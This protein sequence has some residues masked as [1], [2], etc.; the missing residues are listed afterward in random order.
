MIY[1]SVIRPQAGQ[2][3]QPQSCAFLLGVDWMRSTLNR[4]SLSAIRGWSVKRYRTACTS[5]LQP[6][7]LRKAGQY[8]YPLT[9][10][11]RRSGDFGGLSSLS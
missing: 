6:L 7:G 3:T 9:L 5:C 1:F 10:L 11:L 4:R 8:Y 2:I